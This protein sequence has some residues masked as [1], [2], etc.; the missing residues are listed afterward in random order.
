M[1]CVMFLGVTNALEGDTQNAAFVYILTLIVKAVFGV[2]CILKIP[3][4]GYTPWMYFVQI[5]FG[6]Y[7]CFDFSLSAL[8]IGLLFAESSAG[9]LAGSV[10]PACLPV[11]FVWFVLF[12]SL[13]KIYSCSKL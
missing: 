4:E 5:E 10:R 8:S 1:M 12:D 3:T 7:N 11:A 6:P 2:E 9:M 13:R